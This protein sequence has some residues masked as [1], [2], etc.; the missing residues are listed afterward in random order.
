MLHVEYIVPALILSK[1]IAA[2]FYVDQI[3]SINSNHTSSTRTCRRSANIIIKHRMYS[4]VL[5]I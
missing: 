3:N 1:K 2:I 5:F 4:Q